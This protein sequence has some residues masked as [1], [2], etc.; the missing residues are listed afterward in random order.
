MKKIVEKTFLEFK[1]LSNPAY[2]PDGKNIAFKVSTSDYENNRNLNDLYVIREDKKTHRVT[3]TGN[4]GCF[5][6]DG[7][8]VHRLA[9]MEELHNWMDKYLK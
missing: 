8:P 7:L 4:V 2:S 1:F 6:W 5:A 9:R 3:S